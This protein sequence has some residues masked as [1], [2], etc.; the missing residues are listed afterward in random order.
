MNVNNPT[1]D[2]DD[3]IYNSAFGNPSHP[4]SLS[5]LVNSGPFSGTVTM[6]ANVISST[7]S[8]SYVTTNDIEKIVAA[9][10]EIQ[11]RL[12]ILVPDPEKLAKHQAL[13]IAYDNYK[14]IE[15]LL[16]GNN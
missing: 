13:K 14:I 2:I 9:L 16:L 7:Y 6:P 10:A 1:D 12:S 5:R 15:A 4:G 11:E 3:K 8:S